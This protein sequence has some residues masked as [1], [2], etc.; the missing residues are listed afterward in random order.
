MIRLHSCSLALLLL[1]P[2]AACH[3]SGSSSTST[4]LASATIGPAGG[5]VVVSEGRQAGLQLIVPAG[6]LTSAE[7]VRVL[8]GIPRGVSSVS[9]AILPGDPFVIEPLGLTLTI[10]ATLRAPFRV[11]RVVRTAPG[12]VRARRST[13]TSYIDYSPIAI[14]LDAGYATFEL[15]VFGRMQ[16]VEAEA[17]SLTDYV[18]ANGTV[19]LEGGA[20]FTVEGAPTT[21]PF[22]GLAVSSWRFLAAGDWQSF[23]FD[24]AGNLVG[25]ETAYWAETWNEPYT[26]WQDVRLGQLYGLDTATQV[27]T[28]PSNPAIGG[29]MTASASFAFTEPR[30]F[31]DELVLDAARLRID[32]A[33][34]R[35][36]LGVGQAQWQFVFAP[37]RGLLSLTLDG[38]AWSRL[39]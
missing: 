14:D 37:D 33:W 29:H 27:R 20:S 32:L 8:D 6:A 21:G 25:R 36:D 1:L 16:I 10:P 17:R 31:G 39:P 15:R 34:N 9:Q 28:P 3:G 24:A 22:V 23:Y 12:N 5:I 38:V 4:V 35:V 30:Q 18:P 2:F 7:Q 19:Q 13:D 26:V 11:E